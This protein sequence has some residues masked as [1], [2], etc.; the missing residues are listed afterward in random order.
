MKKL[1]IA[2]AIVCAAALSQAASID[3]STAA[4]AW[5]WKNSTAS[6]KEVTLYLVNAAEQATIITAINGGKTSFTTGDTGILGLGITTTVNT[7]GA[8]NVT[9]ATSASLVAGTAYDYKVL[10]IDTNS[11]NGPYYQFSSAKN[12]AA[13]DKS[14]EVYYETTSVTFGSSD[15][16]TSG[17]GTGWVQVAPEPTSALLLLLGVAGLALRRRRA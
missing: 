8:V 14:D 4:N 9:P 13:Y 12:K 10:I 11:P 3:W 2:A 16:T 1:M 5:S 17:G 15:F 7:K 6:K